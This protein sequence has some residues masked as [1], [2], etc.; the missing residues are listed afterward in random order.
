[1]KAFVQQHTGGAASVTS[2]LTSLASPTSGSA[3]KP[4]SPGAVVTVSQAKQFLGDQRCHSCNRPM[5]K[6]AAKGECC[7]MYWSKCPNA[8]NKT[9]IER[10]KMREADF[11]E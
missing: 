5:G 4:T 10:A 8:G 1:M 9:A 6:D 2:A 7:G 3:A 11:R